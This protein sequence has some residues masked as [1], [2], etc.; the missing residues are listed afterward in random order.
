MKLR[1]RALG[2]AFGIIAGLACFS[3]TLLSEWFGSGFTL[4]LLKVVMPGY[5]V[6][7]AGAFVGLLWGFVYGFVEGSLIAWL[8]NQFCKVLY[9]S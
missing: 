6:S 4:S 2:L 7:Y 8:Y 3:A 5:S 1:G 9:K